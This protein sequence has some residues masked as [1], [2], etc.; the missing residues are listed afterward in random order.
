M[1][2]L[3]ERDVNMFNLLLIVFYPIN[4]GFVLFCVLQ[5]WDLE[6]LFH[7]EVF[8]FVYMQG[9]DLETLTL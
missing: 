1:T 7:F 6:S 5:G 2:A 8:E 9:W 4:F 3:V